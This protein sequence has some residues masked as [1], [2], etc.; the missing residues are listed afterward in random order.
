V[1]SR[2]RLAA[3]PT[4]QL[5][6]NSDGSPSVRRPSLLRSSCRPPR[7]SMPAGPPRLARAFGGRH[8]R[9]LTLSPAP[10]CV[11]SARPC[12]PCIPS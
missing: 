1:M 4:D 2:G 5:H 11:G 9:S 7:G 6:P 3:R 10:S 8:F 12:R